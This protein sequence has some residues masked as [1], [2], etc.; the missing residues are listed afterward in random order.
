MS[1]RNIRHENPDVKAFVKGLEQID[2]Y[3]RTYE[4]FRDFCELAY[5]AHAKLTALFVGN[6]ERADRLEERYMSIVHTY[7]DPDDVR[8]F[9]PLLEIVANN[10]E[11]GGI[12]FLGTVAGQMEILDTKYAG[13][14]FTPYQVS[15]MM[16]EMTLQGIEEVI[17]RDGYFTLSEP[18]AG[19]GG[20]ILAVADVLQG[21]GFDPMKY[22]LVE[23]VDISPMAFHMCYLQLTFRGVPALVH[24]GN[25][26]SMEMFE[27]AW[28]P[29]ATIFAS[30]HPYMF[31]KPRRERPV[32][33]QHVPE[34]EPT[35][36]AQI[37]EEL[38]AAMHAGDINLDD[39]QQFVQKPLFDMETL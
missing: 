8:A 28:T 26:L 38:M 12:D 17:E 30:Y 36:L 18:A 37:L 31:N 23:A 16:A 2:R 33:V 24:R 10:L 25:S 29:P 32:E 14:F 34:P 4:K 20:M 7:K 5:C 6:Q 35:D 3:R 9:K 15:R 27:S 13:Q 22:M 1:S 11:M 19:A 21:L 39:M